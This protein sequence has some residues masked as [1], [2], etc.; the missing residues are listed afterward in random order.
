MLSVESS[1]ELINDRVNNFETHL[2]QTLALLDEADAE[3][4]KYYANATRLILDSYR[5]QVM[6]KVIKK[7][8]R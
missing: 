8:D 5:M 1:L 3:I 7:G 6:G 2:E 4:T